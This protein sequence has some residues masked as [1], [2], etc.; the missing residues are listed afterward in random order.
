MWKRERWG[1]GR[2][3]EC[4]LEGMVDVQESETNCH[5][6]NGV[7]DLFCALQSLFFRPNL[8]KS[9]LPLKIDGSLRTPS[10][11][12]LSRESPISTPRRRAVE[13][14]GI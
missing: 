10:S 11:R 8:P 12:S 6:T 5:S 2:V 13:K 4:R 14:T 1:E 3:G 7:F 9:H